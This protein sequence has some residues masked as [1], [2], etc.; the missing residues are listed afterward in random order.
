VSRVQTFGRA[1]PSFLLLPRTDLLLNPGVRFRKISIIGVGLLGGSLGLAIRRRHLAEETSGFVRRSATADECRKRRVVDTVTLD[2]AEAVA[3]ADFVILCTSV[4]QM[5]G[6]TECLLPLLRRGAIVTD[7]G[8]VKGQVVRELESIINARGGRFVGSHPM[9][10]SER[11]GVLAARDNLFEQAVCVTTPT[12]RTHGGALRKVERFWKQVGSRVVR[13]SPA[14]HDAVVA[15]SSHLPHLVAAALANLVLDPSAH[16][17][18]PALSAGGFR[19][20][21][22]I[23]S[24]S[25]EMWRDIVL[26]NRRN[27]VRALDAFIRDL[28][29][30]RRIVGAGEEEGVLQFLDKAKRRRDAW[31]A[32]SAPSS[33]E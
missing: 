32:R 27:I 21:T 4:R 29:K 30:L 20:A 33:P 17:T 7:V 3:G 2:L 8:S 13:L 10:G 19:D 15:R 25:P 12:S 14:V 24:G 5:R 9:A 22:R 18:Q 23:A 11:A 26:G 16:E 1:G 31:G 6:L 28:K